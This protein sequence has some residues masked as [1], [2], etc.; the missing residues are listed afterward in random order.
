MHPDS[1]RVREKCDYLVP[2]PL[3]SSDDARGDGGEG[4]AL[5]PDSPINNPQ[6]APR[7]EEKP[8]TQIRLLDPACGTMHFGHY[9]MEV[10]EAMYRDAR[11]WGHVQIED[12]R[13]PGAI[14]EYNLYGVD[15]D[16]RAVQLAAL[17]LFMKARTMHPRARVRQVNLVVADATMP[18]SGVRER[19]LAR[20][21][22]TP[23]VREAFAQVLDDMDQVA[24][25]GSLLRVEERLRELLTQA[26]HAVAVDGLR[27]QRQRELPGL[28]P[29][30]RQMGLAE[31]LEDE[32]QAV[33]VTPHYTLQELRDDLRDFARRALQEHDLN[34]Q[35]FAAEADRAVRL[36]D[37]LM[38]DYDVVVMN[39]PYTNTMS[40]AQDY[41]EAAYSENSNNLYTAF[42]DRAV[43]LAEEQGYVGAITSSTFLVRKTYIGIRKNILI[44]RAPIVTLAD[45]GWEVLDDAQVETS[46]FVFKHSPLDSGRQMHDDRIFFDLSREADKESALENTLSELRTGEWTD[47][48]FLVR[49]SLFRYLPHY[50]FAYRVSRSILMQFE[51]N[52]P[53]DPSVAHAKTGIQVPGAETYYKYF[54]EVLPKKIGREKRWVSLA[55]GG[56]FSPFYRDNPQV[57]DWRVD[58]DHFRGRRGAYLRNERFYFKQGLTWSKRTNWL[59]FTLL[60]A[61]HIFSHEGN[62]LFPKKNA[63]QWYL[64]A[65][66][67]S[68]LQKKLINMICAVHKTPGYIA[69]LP[70]VD[71]TQDLRHQLGS[72]AREAHNLK[73][74]W[75][76]GN[77]ICTRFTRPWLSQLTRPESDA[78][79]QG[80]G[81]IL[82][83]LGDDAPPTPSP[84]H[85][86]TLAE[87]LDCARA[88][89]DVAD[90]R[91]QGLQAEIDEAVY[92]LYEIGPADRALIER[93]LGDRPPELVWPLMAGKSDREKRREH[94]RR[95]FS[96]YAL[97]AVRADEDGIVP[98]AGCA[99]REP[100]LVDRVRAQLEAQFGH[101]VAYQLE[102]AHPLA[103]HQ[104]QGAF[105]GDGR[106]P[107]P[108]R[109]HAAQGPLAL[110]LAAD[111]R[112]AHA[113]GR[114]AGRGGV[115]GH[116]RRTGGGTG[117][118]GGL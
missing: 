94:V 104:P 54:W 103:P 118:P 69:R 92:D 77:E 107:P 22:R 59:H 49:P 88:I 109:R 3:P 27:L 53:L 112:G 23:Q 48:A 67:N 12:E 4:F 52:D 110:S 64:L 51:E 84:P 15:I 70:Y 36:L 8:V 50:A 10:F 43:G 39:P 30:V 19:F 98:L 87:L 79:A 35:L 31:V 102:T 105:R 106:L 5:D 81:R 20:Y 100:T 68:Q 76:T 57:I 65:L 101:D 108:D 115:P 78:F 66:L 25:V 74:V 18:D 7:R 63:D 42:A 37:V 93:E 62:G 2:E 97:Q 40:C 83:L 117:R 73:A 111:G 75:D 82:E 21:A 86:L 34:A 89:E 71:G 55:N 90:A 26:G 96:Y 95:L 14:L 114:G 13:I 47:V 116:D 16:R 44:E 46:A 1:P 32:E 24:Q 41:I 61:G 113:P 28:E 29:G 60:P 56:S 72:A 85:S 80:L 6:A 11:D 33:L 99:G 38:T 9:A 58:G 17:S 45:L 91:L